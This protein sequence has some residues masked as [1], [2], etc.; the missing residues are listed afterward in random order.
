MKKFYLTPKHFSS[1][2]LFLVF[3]PSTSFA[4]VTGTGLPWEKVLQVISQSLSGP[5]ATSLSIICLAIGSMIL[6]FGDV[7]KGA[8]MIASVIVGFSIVT[9]ALGIMSLFGLTGALM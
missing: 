7:N 9:S 2:V 4:S 3:L 1:A 5:V 6:M 8:R